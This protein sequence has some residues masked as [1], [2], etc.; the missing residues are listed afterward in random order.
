MSIQDKADKI[1]CV[2]NKLKQVNAE[3]HRKLEAL[4]D[5]ERDIHM[6]EHES[7]KLAKDLYN[8]L[9]ETTNESK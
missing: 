6:L 8:L 2:N 1:T 5:T 9:N 3:W 7:S 4:T